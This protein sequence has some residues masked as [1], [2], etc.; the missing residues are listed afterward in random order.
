MQ[1]LATPPLLQYILD[2]FYQQSF[3]VRC[4]SEDGEMQ[5]HTYLKS[6]WPLRMYEDHCR[7]RLLQTH[8]KRKIIMRRPFSSF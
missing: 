1:A 8:K 5:H 6:T 3:S 7:T 2:D 4:R